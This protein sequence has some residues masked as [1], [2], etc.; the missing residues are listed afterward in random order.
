MYHTQHSSFKYCLIF[1]SYVCYE[2]FY[3]V[4]LCFPSFN[5]RST[6]ILSTHHYWNLL[7]FNEL[8]LACFVGSFKLSMAAVEKREFCFNSEKWSYFHL[9]R[10]SE[11]FS[12]NWGWWSRTKY[13]V[14][15]VII[16]YLGFPVDSFSCLDPV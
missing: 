16:T 4:L 1:L 3:L 2:T 10:V 9:N 15:A 5:S 13:R 7:I 8:A 14:R 11:S 6:H 12:S